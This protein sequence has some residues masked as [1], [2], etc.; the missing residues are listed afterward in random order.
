MSKNKNVLV[1]IFGTILLIGMIGLLVYM[2]VVYVPNQKL[3][4]YEDYQSQMREF[5]SCLDERVG[6]YWSNQEH[7]CLPFPKEEGCRDLEEFDII[8]TAELPIGYNV[9][10]NYRDD[11]IEIRIYC[12]GGFIKD[13]NKTC[14]ETGMQF[15]GYENYPNSEIDYYRV[16]V[17]YNKSVRLCW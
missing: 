14:H 7:K 12:L 16:M 10:N 1:G 9:T 11:E 8:D 17:N 3:K 15:S 5:Y 2:L 4:H 6:Y 13:N